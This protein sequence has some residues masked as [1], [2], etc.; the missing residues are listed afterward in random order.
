MSERAQYK[1][2]TSDMH[3]TA[4]EVADHLGVSRQLVADIENRVLKKIRKRM[5]EKGI[6]AWDILPD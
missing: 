5:L 2:N 1:G 6:Q 4:Q 3:M